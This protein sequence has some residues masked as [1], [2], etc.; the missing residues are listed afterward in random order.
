MGA[1]LMARGALVR[2]WITIIG[3]CSMLTGCAIADIDECATLNGGCEETCSNSDGSD[4]KS[5]AKGK[6][7][8]Q[9]GGKTG[10]GKGLE[11][12]N[13]SVCG[14]GL[15]GQTRVLKTSE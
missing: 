2:D 4:R 9:G 3:A 7:G 13:G 10:A 15:A 5:V 8:V 1:S 14:W 11:E 12:S 6:N